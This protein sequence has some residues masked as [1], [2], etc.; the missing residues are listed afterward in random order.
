MQ[1]WFVISELTFVRASTVF[2]L[3]FGHYNLHLH[4]TH[5]EL[6]TSYRGVNRFKWKRTQKFT[7][8]TANHYKLIS[9]NYVFL[10]SISLMYSYCSPASILPHQL[11][12]WTF[13]PPGILVCS[14]YCHKMSAFSMIQACHSHHFPLPTWQLHLSVAD[15]LLLQVMEADADG[16]QRSSCVFYVHLLIYRQFS[17]PLNGHKLDWCY[18]SYLKKVP[19]S[20]LRQLG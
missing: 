13:T 19:G 3:S 5:N 14:A 7:L 10:C 11:P 15:W 2:M 6:K 8:W 16:L 18:K 1:K 4:H 17:I 12:L 20:Q 9:Y